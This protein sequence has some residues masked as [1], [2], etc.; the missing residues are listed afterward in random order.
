MKVM[1]IAPRFH[2]NQAA[3]VKGWLAHGDEVLFVSYYASIIEDY[4]SI[5]PVVLGFTPVFSIIDKLYMEVLYRKDAAAS[6]FKINHG[7]PPVLKLRRVIRKWKPDVIILRDRTLYTIAG[8]LLG[9]KSKCILYNQSPMWDNP[10]KRDWKHRLVRGLTPKYRMTPVMG[11]KEPGKVIAEHSY[12]IP[13]V[14]EPMIPPDEKKYFR[15]DRIN[16]LCIGKFEPRKHHMMLMD[17]VSELSESSDEK[18]HLTVIGEATKKS[19]KEFLE[20]VRKHVEKNHYRDMVTLVTNVSKETVN[21]YYAKSDVYVIPSTDEPASVSQ[22]E[23]MGFSIPVICSDSNGSACYVK[24]GENGYRFRDCDREDLK[25][26]LTM[27]LG[28]RE[29]IVDMGAKAYQSVLSCNSFQS[30]YEGV[31]A[32]LRDMKKDKG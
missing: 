16:V 21:E 29:K 7:I 13:F 32:I 10:P 27:L 15:D 18:Y 4:S 31:Q 20:T 14:A 2:T 17:I 28:S 30:Y 5:R 3:V 9:K 6:N 12:F 11:E 26:K 23:A 25:K 1:Y 19:H 24:E 22:L 8:Y